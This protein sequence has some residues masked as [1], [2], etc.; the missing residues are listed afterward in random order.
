MYFLY[1]LLTFDSFTYLVKNDA[2]WPKLATILIISCFYFCFSNRSSTT[3]P[4]VHSIYSVFTCSFELLDI[5]P[6]AH[7][8]RHFGRLVIISTQLVSASEHLLPFTNPCRLNL[9][10]WKHC[11]GINLLTVMPGQVLSIFKKSALKNAHF[12]HFKFA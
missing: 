4:V 3:L 2:S 10:T 8:L 12:C 6:A 1:V 11:I 7:D 9:N 5:Y